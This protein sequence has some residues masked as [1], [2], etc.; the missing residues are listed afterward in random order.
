MFPPPRVVLL[1]HPVLPQEC[2]HPGRYVGHIKAHTNEAMRQTIRMGQ[3]PR[4]TFPNCWERVLAFPQR[5][6]GNRERS[7]Q[8]LALGCCSS[9]PTVCFMVWRLFIV[10]I[11]PFPF[12]SK[13]LQ[14]LSYLNGTQKCNIC[15]R[16][17]FFFKIVS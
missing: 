4:L 7:Q 6:H 15:D 2:T 1:M 9:R 10:P 5:P 17:I 13:Q 12:K 3:P 16:F 11:F 8:C 14:Y